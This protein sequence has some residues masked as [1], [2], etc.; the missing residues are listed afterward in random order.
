[1][2]EDWLVGMG[3][4]AGIG[5]GRDP[6]LRIGLWDTE[7]PGCGETDR[8]RAPLAA[9]GRPHR[10]AELPEARRSSDRPQT[11]CRASGSLPM[12]LPK[13]P[14]MSSWVWGLQVWRT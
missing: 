8:S 2:Q 5:L 11:Q 13:A 3:F 4:A 9:R 6:S 1:M 10:P 7:D 12:T 14:S